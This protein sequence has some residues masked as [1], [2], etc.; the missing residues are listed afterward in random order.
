MAVNEI[1]ANELHDRI[2]GGESL[3]LLDVRNPEGYHDWKI[4]GAQ[5]QSINIPYFD[6]LE[7]NEEVYKDLPKNTEI[8]V[9]CAKGASAQMVSE[10]LDEKGYN[11][12][13]LR[14]GML[15]WSQ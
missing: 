6:F 11:V 10:L 8:V 5:L 7:E 4:E 3:L 15:G 2:N 9:I 1:R 12:S 14:E 13:Y